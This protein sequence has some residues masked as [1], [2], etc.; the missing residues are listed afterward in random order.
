MTITSYALTMDKVTFDEAVRVLGAM[1]WSPMAIM[2][3]LNE[4]AKRAATLGEMIA[5][6]L[7]DELVIDL[8]EEV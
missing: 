2:I 8:V 1:G 5:E 4:R 3:E 7:D 6:E